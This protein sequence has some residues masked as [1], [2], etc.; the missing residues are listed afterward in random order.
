MNLLSKSS[1]SI[2]FLVILVLSGCG[3]SIQSSQ[4]DFDAISE[5]ITNIENAESFVEME[6]AVST[7]NSLALSGKAADVLNKRAKS[8]DSIEFMKL[9]DEQN[10]TGVLAQKLLADNRE[11]FIYIR[12]FDWENSTSKEWEILASRLPEIC[13][14]LKIHNSYLEKISEILDRK[15]ILAKR[16]SVIEEMFL[17]D[18][19]GF[20]EILQTLR[21]SQGNILDGEKMGY[22]NLGCNELS[23]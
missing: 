6:K 23:S 5:N 2:I 19:N 14:Q 16:A 21:K 17:G 1:P 15:I 11:I 9:T 4:K 8:S 13:S 18:G 12:A 22:K 7:H 3:E 10:R 20:L